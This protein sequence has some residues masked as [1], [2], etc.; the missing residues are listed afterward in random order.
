M[1]A[2]NTYG[3]LKEYFEHKLEMSI[4]SKSFQDNMDSKI[5]KLLNDLKCEIYGEEVKATTSTSRIKQCLAYSKKLA[6]KHRPVLANAPM[7]DGYQYFTDSAFL[8]KL[9]KEDQIDILPKE[10]ENYPNIMN[11][12]PNIAVAKFEMYVKAS[13]IIKHFKTEQAIELQLDESNTISFAKECISKAM[14]FGNVKPTDNLH[15]YFNG[16]MKPFVIMNGR[17]DTVIIATPIR[18]MSGLPIYKVDALGNLVQ[19]SLKTTA[20]E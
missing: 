19:S 8:V 18:E 14:L 5:V 11:I 6:K 17:N 7:F 4:D 1:D 16:G 12:I 15:M 13:E 3:I 20:T 9:C 2:K 10:A